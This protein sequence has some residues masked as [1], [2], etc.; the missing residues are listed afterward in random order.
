MKR[1]SQ[2]PLPVKAEPPPG[3]SSPAG[4]PV[5]AA[6]LLSEDEIFR[7]PF[8]DFTPSSR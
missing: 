7:D 1:P 5:P 2:A 3:A 4:T 8:A 6:P